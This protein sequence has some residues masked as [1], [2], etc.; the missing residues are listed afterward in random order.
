MGK[1]NTTDRFAWSGHV[2]RH[3]DGFQRADAL[4]NRFGPSMGQLTH[5]LHCLLVS[6]RDEISGSKC[7]PQ[8]QPRFLVSDEKDAF[9]PQAL[10]P[11]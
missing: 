8:V 7:L 6:G 11:I 5:F 9:G 2:K 4:Q 3:I 1:T 10:C